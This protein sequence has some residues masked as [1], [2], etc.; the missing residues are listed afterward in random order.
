MALLSKMAAA[1]AAGI[2]RPTLYRHIKQGKVSVTRDGDG[3][4]CVDESE[5]FRAYGKLEAIKE[6]AVTVLDSATNEGSLRNITHAKDKS[7]NI[8]LLQYKIEALTKQ[9]EEEKARSNKLLDI[10][11]STT[12]ALPRPETSKKGFL[13]RLFE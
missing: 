7:V 5:I 12:L 2:S 1:K 13:S 3:N 10:V 8:E 9:L 11:E 4:S 6:E